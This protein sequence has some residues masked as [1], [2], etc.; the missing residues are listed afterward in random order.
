MATVFDNAHSL[1]NPPYTNLSSFWRMY[2][3]FSFSPILP[4]FK[5]SMLGFTGSSFTEPA[6]SW[7][8]PKTLTIEI[9]ETY[10]NSTWITPLRSFMDAIFNFLPI[11]RISA[12]ASKLKTSS[13]IGPNLSDNSL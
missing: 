2:S 13:G 10:A 1:P 9:S 3:L 7:I 8:K 6:D 11:I 12:N 5:K 4:I